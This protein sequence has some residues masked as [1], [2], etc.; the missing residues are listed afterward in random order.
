MYILWTE[1]RSGYYYE[2]TLLFYRFLYLIHR[3]ALS[4][5]LF[6]YPISEYIGDSLDFIHENYKFWK[7]SVKQPA[8]NAMLSETYFRRELKKYCGVPPRQYILNLRIEYAKQLLQSELYSITE[9]SQKAG[10]DD[11]KYFN[12]IFK[13]RF[14]KTPK[15]YQKNS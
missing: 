12:R 10:F 8:K 15:E 7:I 1:K 14:G 3:C 11:P 9:V 13:H 4:E 5:T 6:R 2:C